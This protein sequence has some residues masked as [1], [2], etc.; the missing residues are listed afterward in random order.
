MIIKRFPQL[1]LSMCDVVKSSFFVED[2]LQIYQYLVFSLSNISLNETAA[3][4]SL[5]GVYA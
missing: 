3:K 2:I 4:R 1:F 5:T